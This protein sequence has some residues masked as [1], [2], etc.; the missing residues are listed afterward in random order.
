MKSERIALWLSLFANLAVLAGLVILVAELRLNTLATQALLYQDN[1][2]YG[3]ENAALLVGDENKELAAI[4]FRAESDPD[5]LSTNEFEKFLL[6]TSWR[7][8]MW[9][10][11]FLHRDAGLLE[12]RYWR[13]LD[14]WFSSILYRGPGYK[15]WWE[16][17]RHGYDAAFQNH[18]DEA[19]ERQ[20]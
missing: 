7:M 10:T 19:F 3:R 2:N 14:A 4:V 5:S 12:E 20:P 13:N 18:V 1:L 11:Q 17:A 6:F 9:E 15:R 16:A 8:G